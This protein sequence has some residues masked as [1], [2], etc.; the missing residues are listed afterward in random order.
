M[1]QNSNRL[2][3]SFKLWFRE[4]EQAEFMNNNL[5]LITCYINSNYKFSDSCSNVT[6]LKSSLNTLR[7]KSVVWCDKNKFLYK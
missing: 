2:I 1:L 7:V 6:L 4:H 3:E 5:M